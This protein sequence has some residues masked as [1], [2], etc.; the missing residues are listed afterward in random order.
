MLRLQD[1]Q[2]E[3]I[4]SSDGGAKPPSGSFGA[5]LAT[6]D[7]ILVEMGGTA[8]GDTTLSTLIQNGDSRQTCYCLKCCSMSMSGA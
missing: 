3:I 1:S 5:V 2:T 8:Y 7:T 6:H 4:L